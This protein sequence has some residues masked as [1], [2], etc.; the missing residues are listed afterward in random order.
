[1][2]TSTECREDDAQVRLESRWYQIQFPQHSGSSP[3][4]KI[5]LIRAGVG[6]ALHR[7]TKRWF[8]SSLR[9]RVSSS[10]FLE[11]RWSWSHFCSQGDFMT[12]VSVAH[13]WRARLEKGCWKMTAFRQ[14]LAKL[15][16]LP[17]P[18][19]VSKYEKWCSWRRR[20]AERKCSSTSCWIWLVVVH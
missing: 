6:C 15:N 3:L 10:P 8:S 18:S 11:N 7:L 16:D 12:A 20:V 5:W 14:N 1:M 19:E 2:F 4:W 17:K 13:R 9:T